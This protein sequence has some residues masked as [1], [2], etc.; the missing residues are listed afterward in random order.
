MSALRCSICALN[1]PTSLAGKCPEC[2]GG[3]SQVWSSDAMSD[4]E[5]RSRV[6][7]AN[8]RKWS[9]AETPEQREQRQARFADELAARFVS[10]LEQL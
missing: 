10:Q 1:W 4:D 6:A 7:H 8:F 9:D 2:D 5:S 3:L